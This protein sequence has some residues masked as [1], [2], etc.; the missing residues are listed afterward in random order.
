MGVAAVTIT[1]FICGSQKYFLTDSSIAEEENTEG[2]GSCDILELVC[3][4]DSGSRERNLHRKSPLDKEWGNM[5]TQDHHPFPLREN[6]R[7]L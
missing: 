4:T 5:D 3:F 7:H 1:G 6:R 2:D